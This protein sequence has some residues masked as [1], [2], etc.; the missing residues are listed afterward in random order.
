MYLHDDSLRNGKYIVLVVN[1][2]KYM[3]FKD[4]IHKSTKKHK[5]SPCLI[6][7]SSGNHALLQAALPRMG[8]TVYYLVSV[9]HLLITHDSS[10]WTLDFESYSA[11]FQRNEACWMSVRTSKCLFAEQVVGDFQDKGISAQRNR[12]NRKWQ[13]LEADTECMCTTE[14]ET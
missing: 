6:L 4:K 7:R 12:D 3:L 1:T 5:Y 14:T 10:Q 9:S 11:N 13:P 2:Q 8:S